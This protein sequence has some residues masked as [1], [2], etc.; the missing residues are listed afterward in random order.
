MFGIKDEETN[1]NHVLKCDAS[2]AND[3][4]V[5]KNWDAEKRI[6][7]IVMNEAL[8]MKIITTNKVGE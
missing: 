7:I 5:M 4:L 1:A 2:P 8:A 6:I 3:D